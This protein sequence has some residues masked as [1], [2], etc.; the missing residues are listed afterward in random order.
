VFCKNKYLTWYESLTSTPSTGPILEKHHIVPKSIVPN[1]NLV[2]LTPRE[3]YIAHLLLIKCVN[4]KYRAKMLYAIT[5]MKMRTSKDIKINSRVF[6]KLK[7]EAN[8]SRSAALKGRTHSQEAREKIKAKRALQVFSAETKAKMSAG[9]KG[10]KKSADAIEKVRQAHLGS[11]RSEETKQRLR[12][13]RKSYPRVTCEYCNTTMLTAHYN[14]WHGKY[15]LSNPNKIERI[16]N[17]NTAHASEKSST[18][19]EV[20]GVVYNSIKDACAALM[21]P[22]NLL[23]LMLN[24]GQ[25][26][27][28]K[29]KISSVNLITVSDDA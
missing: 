1:N 7:I 23:R 26:V 12:E 2:A 19:I 10:K 28:L 21:L 13:S 18:K 15:C 6:E 24:K 8:I 17:V 27:N 16:V 25:H 5:A 4:P 3:H 22:R 20:N 9:R 14:R 29:Y 11:K